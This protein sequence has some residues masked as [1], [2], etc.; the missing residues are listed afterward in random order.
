MVSSP[1]AMTDVM[2][3]AGAALAGAA[4][5]GYACG[6][7]VMRA[8]AYALGTDPGFSLIDQAYVWAGMRLL[9]LLLF[10]VLL[11]ALPIL[12]IR[13]LWHQ[14]LRF[15]PRPLAVVE[16]TAAVLFGVVIMLLAI[17]LFGVSNVIFADRHT[18]LAAP[19]PAAVLGRNALGTVL[20]VGSTA[21]AL[22]IVLWIRSRVMRA[23]GLDALA[24]LLVVMALLLSVLLPIEH[25]FFFAERKVRQLERLPEGVTGLTLPIWIV[26]QGVGDRI[27][28]F[29]RD[30][31]GAARLVAV[32]A[33]KLDGIAVTAVADLGDVL[34]QGPAR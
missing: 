32:K 22:L 5:A 6:Y 2:K 23:N 28:L 24:M 26:E 13:W 34:M 15:G 17:N 12:L 31:A 7:L 4:A 27:V 11:S 10:A 29:G 21:L 16:A 3:D 1:P 30:P 19:L 18:E 33:D 14:L 9:L 20:F 25:G 8:R